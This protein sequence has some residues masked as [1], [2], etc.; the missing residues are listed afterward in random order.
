MT[1]I[2]YLK[3]KYIT[4]IGKCVK[5]IPEFRQDKKEINGELRT[6]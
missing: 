1:V 5:K 3:K 4:E 6:P 2:T